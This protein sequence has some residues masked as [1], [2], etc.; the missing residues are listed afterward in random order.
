MV[1][2][3]ANPQT[4]SADVSAALRARAERARAL[5]RWVAHDDAA[6]T[7]REY[8]DELEMKAAAAEPRT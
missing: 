6:Q 1:C 3:I 7:L 2:D 8:A 4:G 5:A